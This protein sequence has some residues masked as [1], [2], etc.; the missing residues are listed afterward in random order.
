MTELPLVS[1]VTPSYNQGRYLEETI[2]SVLNQDYPE[3]EYIVID[4][5]SNDGSVDIIRKYSDRLAYWVS[6]PDKGQA[7]AL[8][9]GFARASG[10]IQAYLN[11]DDVYLPGAVSAA[12]AALTG[13]PK[14]A[15]VH[16]DC[17]YIDS[18]GQEIGRRVGLDGDFLSFFLQQLNPILQ[19]SAF[20][21]AS[22][23]QAAGGIDPSLHL[24][25]DY[26]LWCR[27]GLRGLEIEHIPEPL[28]MFRIH[29]ESKTRQNLL[30]FVQERWSLLDQYFCDPALRP[31]IAEHHDRIRAMAH[32][33]FADAHWMLHENQEAYN[34]YRQMLRLAPSCILSRVSLS[35][36]LR[37]LLRRPTLR[38]RMVDQE[39]VR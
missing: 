35:L 30:S 10:G 28:S 17:I 14:L 19:P 26:D 34:H 22:A 3:I 11:S 8:Y 5:G 18:Q 38:A 32:L 31:R 6:E 20:W 13:N 24:V 29:G 23:Y 7:D 36:T 9:K 16:A 4:G 2:L 21:R 1:I 15:L 37:F 33:R 39:A 12:A 27:I 25:M